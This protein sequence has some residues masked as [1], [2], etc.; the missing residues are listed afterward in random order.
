V[1]S[2]AQSL[3]LARQPDPLGRRW[4][5][6]LT[7][8]MRSK[9]LGAIGAVII[10][11]TIFLA[12]IS[13][14]GF[15]DELTGYKYDEQS[16]RNRLQPPSRAHLL[17]TDHLGRDQLSRVVH[18]SRVS[19]SI[20]F[21]AVSVSTVLAVLIGLPSGYFGGK[22][23]TIVQRI[24]DVWMAMPGLIMLIFLIAIFGRSLIVMVMVLGTLTAARVSRLVRGTTL[25]VINEQYVDAARS[26]GATNVRV[27]LLHV[28][29]N[30]FHIVLIAISVSIGSAIL[31]E[32][33][34]S[35]LG[36]GLPPPYPTWGRMLSDSRAFLAYPMLGIIPGVAITVTVFAFN[37][38]GDALR[39]VLDP[40][41]RGST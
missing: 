17:G 28:L 19:I 35:F 27:M 18:G 4:S 14:L 31:V 21:L 3:D 15:A 34:L 7:K 39:D 16:L 25:G 6:A 23:D 24:V 26:L 22:F 40:R 38:L 30:I 10:V 32:S 37:V 33:T 11:I 5:K 9:P 20:G 8:F 29:P 12:S 2:E 13:A 36:L 1:V 41:L